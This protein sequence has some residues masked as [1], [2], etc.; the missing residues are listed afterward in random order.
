[1]IIF[2]SFADYL[3][4]HDYIDDNPVKKY[5]HLARI[6]TFK[7]NANSVDHSVVLQIFNALHNITDK[8]LV[9]C[10][11]L[12]YCVGMRVSEACCIKTDCTEK[13]EKGTFVKYYSLKMKKEVYNVIPTALYEMIEELKAERIGEEYLFESNRLGI[14]MSSSFFSDKLNQEFTESGVSNPDGTPY[15][16]TPHSFRHLMAVRMR[17]NEIPFQFIQEQLHHVSPEMTLAYIEYLD[18]VKIDKMDKFIDSSGNYTKGEIIADLTADEEY[19]DYMRKH[20]NAQM[21]PDGICARPIKLGKCSHANACLTCPDFRT[22]V[23]YL[24]IHRK[25]LESVEQYINTAKENGWLPQVESNQLIMKT[26]KTIIEK[27]EEAGG[28]E[29]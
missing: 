2:Q 17:E 26:L 4:V 6:G 8:R 15:R 22:S 5:R 7:H 1:M 3:L 10:F 27:L 16:F 11:L 18:R 20:I 13:T 29:S 14:P 9:I 25:H 19:A 24:D 21:L 12:L 23:R 28:D